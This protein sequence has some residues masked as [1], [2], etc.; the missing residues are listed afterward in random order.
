MPNTY[1]AKRTTRMPNTYV[2]STAA[3]EILTRQKERHP[4]QILMRQKE[5]HACQILTRQKSDTHDKY[6]CG[7]KSDTHAKYL[8]G[9]KSD[10][11]AKYLRGKYSSN[12]NTLCFIL[13]SLLNTASWK[14]KR[15]ARS[16]SHAADHSHA[17]FW[18][19][20][21]DEYIHSKVQFLP[22]GINFK[23]STI[24]D[25]QTSGP[26]DEAGGQSRQLLEQVAPRMHTWAHIACR[27]RTP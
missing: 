5:R 21:V 15:H 2:A 11:H 27:T 16:I 24:D 9:K 12:V 3:T 8:R 17:V 4:C 18:A 1:A 25:E 14:G 22:W 10:M 13:F 23:T 26:S 19:F 20:S 6:L 7:K